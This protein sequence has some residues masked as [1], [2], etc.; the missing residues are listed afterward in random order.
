MNIKLEFIAPKKFKLI[1][2]FDFYVDYVE[3]IVNL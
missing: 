1:G 3:N 2:L